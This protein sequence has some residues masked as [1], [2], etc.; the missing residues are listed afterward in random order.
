[1]HIAMVTAYIFRS[2]NHHVIT[3]A[4]RAVT[5]CTDTPPAAVSW[6]PPETSLLDLP[7]PPRPPLA[8][9]Y[10]IAPPH[11]GWVVVYPN[12]L[13]YAPFAAAFSRQTRKFTLSVVNRRIEAWDRGHPALTP[14]DLPQMLLDGRYFRDLILPPV[15]DWPQWLHVWSAKWQ[16]GR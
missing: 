8:S 13:Q 9:A 14:D 12:V 10:H 15:L 16:P 2:N 7:L 4:V 3:A 5:G 11:N 6:N 1:M